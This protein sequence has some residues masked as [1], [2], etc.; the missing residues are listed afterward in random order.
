MHVIRIPKN[1]FMLNFILHANQINAS[2]QIV[3]IS[4]PFAQQWNNNYSDD[5]VY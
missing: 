1:G 5:Y 3:R 2:L 4:G